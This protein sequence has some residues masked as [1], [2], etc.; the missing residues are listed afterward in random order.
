MPTP[1]RLLALL[2]ATAA[3]VPAYSQSPMSLPTG[4][5]RSGPATITLA[6]DGSTDVVMPTAEWKGSVRTHADT[7]WVSDQSPACADAG[8]GQYLWSATDDELTLRPVS[9]PC[10]PRLASGLLVWHRVPSEPTVLT[11]TARDYAFEAA[12]TIAAGPITI[13]LHNA[14][15]DFHEVDLV[16]LADGHTMADVAHAMDAR[17]HVR[18]AAELGGVS[19]VAPGGD[20]AVTLDVPAGSYVV[21]C[22]VPDAHGTP[23]AMKGMIRA[24]VVTGPSTGPSTA[25]ISHPDVTVD[26]SEYGFALS[27]PLT[28]GAH[29][30]LV[31]NIGAERHMLILIRLAPGKSTADVL[32]W[33]HHRTGPPPAR[34]IGGVAEMDAGTAVV[35]PMQL[36]A[37]RYALICFADAPDGKSHAEHHMVSAFTIAP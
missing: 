22:G 26:M 11:I 7:V 21:I 25:T 36:S 30:A 37:G 4:V 1:Q 17:Q 9:D 20:A 5:F 13:R 6:A 33:E 16:R 28:A 12:D 10:Q 2:V 19:A 29:V 8:P 3:A 32:A 18:W 23:H 24:L 14:G 15:Q 34:P 27:H 35:W 31:R